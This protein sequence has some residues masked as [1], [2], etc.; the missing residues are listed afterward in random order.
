MFHKEEHMNIVFVGMP[1]S[2]KTTLSEPVA[3]RLNKT[4]VELDTKIE[5]KMGMPLQAYMD[6]YG[7]EAFKDKERQILMDFFQTAHNAV[8]SPPGSLIYYPEL[9]EYIRGNASRFVVFYLKCDLDVVLKRT[10]HFENRGVLL[11][12][13]LENPYQVLYEERTPLYEAMSHHVLDANDS[14]EDNT[15]IIVDVL[16]NHYTKSI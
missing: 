12:K 2:G 14:S 3:K 11:D 7:N 16:D 10:N 6:T 5:E 13:S 9:L 1:G 8:L 15:R 4:F